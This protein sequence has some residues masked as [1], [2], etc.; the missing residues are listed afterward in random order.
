MMYT[1]LFDHTVLGKVYYASKGVRTNDGRR[2]VMIRYNGDCYQGFYQS[3]GMISGYEGTWFPFDGDVTNSTTGEALLLKL[4]N[5]NFSTQFKTFIKK[6]KKSDIQY[7]KNMIKFGTLLF[8]YTSYVLGGGVWDS[9]AQSKKILAN[10][11]KDYFG[12]TEKND[13][14]KWTVRKVSFPRGLQTQKEV[15]MFLGKAMSFNYLKGVEY[16]STFNGDWILDYKD[17]YAHKVYEFYPNTRIV[18]KRPLLTSCPSSQDEI[19]LDFMI[20][21]D[22]NVTSFTNYYYPSIGGL[23]IFEERFCKKFSS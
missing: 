12:G 19:L 10:V 11:P 7:Q 2:V 22:H 15:N 8:L 1:L 9:P 20:E 3:S 23:S 18:F 13:V 4:S 14:R 21:L 16:P 17:I 5:T 6:V